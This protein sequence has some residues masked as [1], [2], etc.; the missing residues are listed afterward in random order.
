M[1]ALCLAEPGRLPAEVR[2]EHLD[3]LRARWGWADQDLLYERAVRST[4]AASARRLQL[5]AELADLDLPVL[6]LHGARDRLVPVSGARRLAR[7]RPHW[8]VR[9]ADHLGHLPMI[10]DPPWVA[11]ALRAWWTDVSYPGRARRDPA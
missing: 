11:A 1:L 7:E 3:L 6:V 10:E 2:A 9:V 5:D 4:I 8:D